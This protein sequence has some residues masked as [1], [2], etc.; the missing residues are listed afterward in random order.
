MSDEKHSQY[1]NLGGGKLMLI[2]YIVMFFSRS[3]LSDLE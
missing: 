2:A 3:G 1:A